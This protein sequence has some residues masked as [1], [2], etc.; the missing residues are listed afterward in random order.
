MPERNTLNVTNAV[1]SDENTVRVFYHIENVG[2]FHHGEIASAN[3]AVDWSNIHEGT[4]EVLNQYYPS[5]VVFL[6]SI[7]YFDI[8]DQIVAAIKNGEDDD[9][10]LYVQIRD[11]FD[12]H[13]VE[14]V[15][16]AKIATQKYDDEIGVEF[17][18]ETEMQTYNACIQ[19]TGGEHLPQMGCWT[20][21]VELGEDDIDFQNTPLEYIGLVSL[22]EKMYS[23]IK[24][25]EE[26]EEGW[27]H[28]ELDNDMRTCL[29]A[30][31]YSSLYIQYNKE[32]DEYRYFF[33]GDGFTQP[34]DYSSM[35]DMII[36]DGYSNIESIMDDITCEEEEFLCS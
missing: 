21:C 23:E 19:L 24:E 32:L 1:R 30:T 11:L 10:S 35:P 34:N 25:K 13:S 6:D 15:D 17:V 8:E 5:D 12:A 2:K 36:K 27:E 22:A 26:N 29:S 7:D 14:A 31:S 3:V 33:K 20:T 9:S 28:V 18:V 16:Y 4:G